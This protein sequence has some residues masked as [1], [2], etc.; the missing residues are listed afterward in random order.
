M[1]NTKQKIQKAAFDLFAKK[2]YDGVS[3][4]DIADKAG[5]TKAMLNYYFRN[6][7]NLLITLFKEAL[8][9]YFLPNFQILAQDLPL[10]ERIKKFTENIIDT[11]IRHP[12]VPLFIANEVNRHAPILRKSLSAFAQNH[13]KDI[14]DN[15][16]QA[17][18]EQ[19]NIPEQN[20]PTHTM[21]ITDMISITLFPFIIRSGLI[22]LCME[23]SAKKFRELMALK[24]QHTT[25]LILLYI[26]NLN[27]Q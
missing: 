9:K 10:E 12:Q 22:E 13:I 15:F 7:E 2:G 16:K 5:V 19:L 21:I 6:K 4:Q 27:K 3:F 20:L 26:N 1:K 17:L 8:E 23:G 11:F 24:K 14:L 25:E 18:Y